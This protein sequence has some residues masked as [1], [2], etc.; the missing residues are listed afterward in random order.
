[1][2]KTALLLASLLVLESGAF[3]QT[4]ALTEATNNLYD[5]GLDNSG[6]LLAS[7]SVDPHYTLVTNPSGTG[8]TTYVTALAAGW[9]ANAT[10][11]TPPSQWISFNTNTTTTAGANAVYD[12][13]LVLSSIPV[14]VVVTISGMVAADDDIQIKA[15]GVSE[16]TNYSIYTSFHSFGFTFTSASTNDLD[17]LV[18]NSGSGPTG[19]QVNQLA[20]Y[21]TPVPEIKGSAIFYLVF[22]GL[23]ALAALPRRFIFR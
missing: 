14:G 6:A 18:N 13:Q 20:G 11:T 8:P 22:A 9:V 3:A 23:L 5:T 21:Y 16:Y 7:S 10:G 15:N 1:V 17:F 4:V 12:Y 19:L 2:I